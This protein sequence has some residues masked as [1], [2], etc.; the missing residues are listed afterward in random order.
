MSEYHKMMRYAGR[1][2]TLQR[3]EVTGNGCFTTTLSTLCRHCEEL[4]VY[5]MVGSKSGQTNTA[6]YC[7]CLPRAH[8]ISTLISAAVVLTSD[9]DECSFIDARTLR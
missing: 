7:E 9:G 5:K 2:Y 4:A 6:T 3:T 8:W 1:V